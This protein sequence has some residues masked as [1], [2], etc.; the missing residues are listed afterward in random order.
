[1]ASNSISLSTKEIDPHTGN[2]SW[3]KFQE[4]AG[5]Q[6]KD[7]IVLR[8]NGASTESIKLYATDA[9]SNSS[10][11]FSLKDK[12]DQQNGIGSWTKLE[13]DQI[14]LQPGETQEVDFIINIPN[15][16]TPGQYF[17][18]IMS[19]PLDITSCP[20]GTTN[21]Q[22]NI[23]VKTRTGNRIY[24]TIP[25]E[26]IE[27]IRL[28]STSTKTQNQ[29]TEFHFAIDN[30]GNI[31]YSPKVNI[32]FYNIFGQRIDMVESS[33][34]Q[35]FPNSTISPVVSWPNKENF[36]PIKAKIR[37][38][39]L[40]I[41]QGRQNNLRGTPLS[42]SL[43]YEFFIFP[44]LWIGILGG[45]FLLLTA[46]LFYQKIHLHLLLTKASNYKVKSDETLEEIA[47]KFSTNWQT[48]AKMNH[49]KAPYT[50]RE[51]QTLRVPK[52]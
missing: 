40:E 48:I 10:G 29:E 17:G 14:T 7:T 2:Q 52:K 39:Y 31:G 47:Q 16:A 36:G 15:T 20:T 34:G 11:S 30:Q 3:F 49:I 51:N 41:D 6:A 37:I 25:G 38:T 27:K 50:I 26:K 8:N 9:Y 22:G 24:L 13:K 43:S 28:I 18:G 12:N 21:C 5:T 33:L 32:D 19:E 1:M 44:W 35:A 4:K 46:I 42:E 45:T 23:K